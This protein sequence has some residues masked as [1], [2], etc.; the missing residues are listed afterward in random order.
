MDAG[1]PSRVETVAVK[2][3]DP[4]DRPSQEIADARTYYDY[5][6]FGAAPSKGDATKTERVADY[7]GGTPVYVTD[8]LTGYDAY[9][10]VHT[11][12]DVAGHTTTSGYSPATGLPTTADVDRP[13]RE[14][15]RPD[16]GDDDHQ[17]AGPRLERCP[18][19]RSTRAV[20]TPTC[21]TTHWAA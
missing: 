11:T 16:L 13:A 8:A 17:H 2:C 1:F 18:S 5:G 6:A 9:G 20:N 12:T 21:S 10:R 14:I 7:S 4:V 15:R 19:P 3:G